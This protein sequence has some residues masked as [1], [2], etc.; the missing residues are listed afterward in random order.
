[1]GDED[2]HAQFKGTLGKDVV[3]IYVEITALYLNVDS[4][5]PWLSRILLAHANKVK[6]KILV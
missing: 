4:R 5:A 2:V 6:H 3:L 1:M